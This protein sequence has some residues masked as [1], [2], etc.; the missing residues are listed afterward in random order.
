MPDFAGKETLVPGTV[1]PDLAGRLADLDGVAPV[2]EHELG[3]GVGHE[4]HPN[5]DP[6]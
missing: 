4:I 2:V 3:V 6:G 1:N 5:L